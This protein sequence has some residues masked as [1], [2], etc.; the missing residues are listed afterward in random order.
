MDVIDRVY[1]SD[2]K[3]DS[4]RELALANV[5]AQG[6]DRTIDMEQTY[7]F[8]WNRSNE[9]YEFWSAIL[10]SHIKYGRLNSNYIKAGHGEDIYNLIYPHHA[11]AKID[12]YIKL[13]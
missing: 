5:E 4:I 12:N 10:D 2:I 9:G 11:K 7:C 3:E 6:G 1:I 8:A 13:I